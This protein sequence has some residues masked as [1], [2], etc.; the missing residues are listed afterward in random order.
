MTLGVAGWRPDEVR[1]LRMSDFWLVLASRRLKAR[2]EAG[3][4]GSEA[5]DRAQWERLMRAAER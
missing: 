1:R 4:Q 3:H 5:D 2:L